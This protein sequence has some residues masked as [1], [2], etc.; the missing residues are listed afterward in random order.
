VP[1]KVPKARKEDHVRA[2]DDDEEEPLL[3]DKDGPT[4]PV[5]AS[6][7]STSSDPKSQQYGESEPSNKTG[8]LRVK[9]DDEGSATE[10]ET[11]SE[12]EDEEEL[13]LGPPN[14]S[15]FQTTQEGKKKRSPSPVPQPTNLPGRRH[16]PT[17]S[18]SP[19]PEVDHHDPGRES[20]R[21]VGTTRPLKDF[22][23]A[24]STATKQGGYASA[25]KAMDDLGFVILE[26]VRKPFV[27]RRRDELVECM[28]SFREVAIKVGG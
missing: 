18:R 14:T 19:S 1:K 13:L 27:S 25:T 2:Q 4:R 24:L 15:T 23:E 5:L 10:S 7:T 16:L 28:R 17:P 20:G 11:E 6:S 8:G 3:L 22:R 26:I 21:V 9:K 12:N